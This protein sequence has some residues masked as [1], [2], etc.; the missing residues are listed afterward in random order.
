MSKAGVAKT[1]EYREPRKC[2]KVSLE[3]R[4]FNS[5]VIVGKECTKCGEWKPL[6][7]SFYKNKE[8]LGGVKSVCKVCQS[9]VDSSVYLVNKKS[10]LREMT[11]WRS[12]NE[13]YYRNY[14]EE[15]K[16]KVKGYVLNWAQKNRDKINIS[17]QRRRARKKSLPDNFTKKQADEVMAHFRYGCALTG[18][19]GIHWDHTIP[20]EVGHGGT[21]YGNM[22]PLRSDLNMSKQDSNI[23][24]WFDSNRQRFE[25]SQ[26]KFDRLIAW[27]A[28]ANDVTVEEYRDYVYWC[29]ANPNDVLESEAI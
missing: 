17:S 25:L 13:D 10:R 15:N 14:Y 7:N 20:L 11:K 5:A 8:G 19:A 4:V 16:E 22:I 6:I 2:K 26:A 12:E 3:E 23:F 21:T 18:D 24:E 27:L 28:A 1:Q 29:H 9:K